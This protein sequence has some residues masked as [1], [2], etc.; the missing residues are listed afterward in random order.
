MSDTNACERIEHGAVTVCNN[1]DKLIK[2]T[3]REGEDD[4]MVELWEVDI[5]PVPKEKKVMEFD[6]DTAYYLGAMLEAARVLHGNSIEA[7][8]K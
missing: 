3:L 2:V 5:R 6:I 7:E 4:L 8:E 1:R